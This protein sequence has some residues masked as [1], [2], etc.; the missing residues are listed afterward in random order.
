ML[1]DGGLLGELVGYAEG[2]GIRRFRAYVVANYQRMLM[3]IQCE[4]AVD[5][6]GAP[7]PPARP[8]P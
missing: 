8:S 1:A 2:R 4:P 5:L 7:M 3:L 6:G